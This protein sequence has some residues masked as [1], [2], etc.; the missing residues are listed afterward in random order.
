LDKI[1]DEIGDFGQMKNDI[2]DNIF[3]CVPILH[4]F[5]AVF[6]VTEEHPLQP[7]KVLPKAIPKSLF[8]ETFLTW[9][10]SKEMDC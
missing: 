6:Y 3:S 2:L 9:N 5:D 7:V 1:L 8:L 10:N 4:F